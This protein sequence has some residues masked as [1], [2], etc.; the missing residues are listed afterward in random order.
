MDHIALDIQP[1][2]KEQ[3]TDHR[4][5]SKFNPEKQT[6]NC[7]WVTTAWL[8]KLSNVNELVA[9]TGCK[10]PTDAGGAYHDEILALLK[11]VHDKMNY[12]VHYWV[13]GKGQSFEKAAHKDS[14]FPEYGAMCYSRVDSGHCVVFKMDSDSERGKIT[15][16]C[17]Q[18]VDDG[19]NV[20]E[21]VKQSVENYTM[22]WYFVKPPQQGISFGKK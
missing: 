2:P 18:W 5:T 16:R 11:A 21:D 14:K 20:H 12:D 9:K 6:N 22:I 13:Q 7:V 3:Y 15:P 1:D 10:Q 17:F 4:I 8:L 19:L